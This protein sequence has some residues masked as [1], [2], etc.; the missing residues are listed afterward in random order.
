EAQEA[1]RAKMLV[2]HSV[3]D[4]GGI[5]GDD[6]QRAIAIAM[7]KQIEQ[8]A[9]GKPAPAFY[10]ILGDCVYFNGE[11]GFYNS[12]F[13]EPYKNYHAAIFAVPGNHDGDTR[14]NRGDP[15]DTESSLFGFMR[16]FCDSVSH[17]DSPYRPTMTQPYVYWVLD[18]PVAT[19]IGLYSN[20]D[21]TLDARG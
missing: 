18:T 7:D 3:G 14:V 20:V 10:Y 9:P 19:I 1:A 5:H 13:Y 6:V 4:S 17:Y 15:P 12:Q 11:S 2:F 8:P 21:G 16:A